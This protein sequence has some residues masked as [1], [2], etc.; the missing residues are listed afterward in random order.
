MTVADTI[1]IEPTVTVTERLRAAWECVESYAEQL[2]ALLVRGASFVARA[3]LNA[4]T[5]L[6]AVIGTIL[7]MIGL[8]S[9]AV[10]AFG[11]AITLGAL[12]AL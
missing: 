7:L 9:F 3:V 2:Q 11:I 8:N 1:T 6:F 4:I 12:A 10:M 5:N